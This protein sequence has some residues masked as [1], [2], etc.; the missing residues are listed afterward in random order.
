[1]SQY[2]GDFDNLSRTKPL[3]RTV[4]NLK[5]V[6]NNIRTI[7]NSLEQ[8]LDSIENFAPTIEMVAKGKDNLV[9]MIAAS[10][11]PTRPIQKNVEHEKPES[12]NLEEDVIEDN[13]Q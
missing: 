10:K 11:R 4:S 13:L 9:S 8:L 3:I 2:K 7:A 6:T 1:M 12:I 5:D